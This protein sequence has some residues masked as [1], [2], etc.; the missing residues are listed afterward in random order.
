MSV[1]DKVT[2]KRDASEM[3]DNTSAQSAISNMSEKRRAIGTKT[4]AFRFRGSN[5]NAELEMLW[6]QKIQ[7]MMLPPAVSLRNSDEFSLESLLS[8]SLWYDFP[9]RIV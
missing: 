5:L 6:R 7:K 4:A 8:K 2:R 1:I 9:Y 3:L